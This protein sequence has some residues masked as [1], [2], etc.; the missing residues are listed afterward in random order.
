MDARPLRSPSRGSRHT[1][2]GRFVCSLPTT[3][4]SIA[5]AASLLPWRSV[6]SCS[7]LLGFPNV[8]IHYHFFVR[9]YNA[10]GPSVYDRVMAAWMCAHQ[11][12]VNHASGR[13]RLTT[14]SA[15]RPPIS[16]PENRYIGD[17]GHEVRP[18]LMRNAIV[19]CTFFLMHWISCGRGAELSTIGGAQPTTCACAFKASHERRSSTAI[20]YQGTGE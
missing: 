1:G 11:L 15:Y 8:Q 13:L 9:S 4:T 14:V 20:V 2:A 3:G 19:D 17:K 5:V 10:P 12:F 18:S 16:R 7:P 6:P